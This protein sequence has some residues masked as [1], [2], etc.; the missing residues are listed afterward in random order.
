M[1]SAPNTPDRDSSPARSLRSRMGSLMRRNTSFGLPRPSTPR[2]STSKGSLKVE[3]PPPE[4]APAAG[5]AVPS[6]VQESPS[7][8]AAAS[9]A[10][11]APAAPAPAGVQ[12]P[13]PLVNE[14]TVTKEPVP[15]PSESAPQAAPSTPEPQPAPPSEPVPVPAPAPA[16]ESAPAQP[17]QPAE[18]PK[19]EEAHVTTEEPVFHASP[20]PLHGELH[21]ASES[22]PDLPAEAYAWGDDIPSRKPTASTEAPTAESSVPHEEASKHAPAPPPAAETSHGFPWKDESQFQMLTPKHSSSSLGASP[23]QGSV[24]ASPRVQPQQ[25][26]TKGSKSSL[27]SSVGQVVVSAAG[28]RVSVSVDESSSGEQKRG[29]SRAGSIRVSFDDPFA[30]PFADPPNAMP[31]A[32]PHM[33]TPIASAVEPQAETEESFP[34]PEQVQ[35]NP[36]SEHYHPQIPEPMVLPLPSLSSVTHK[37]SGYSLGERTNGHS[38]PAHHETDERLPLLPRGIDNNAASSSKAAGNAIA[39]PSAQVAVWPTAGHSLRSLGW[40]EYVLPD[41][42]FY[43]VNKSTRVVTDID[44]RNAKKLEA[45]T[46]YLDRKL[47]EEVGLAPEGWELWLREA[48]ATK[49]GFSPLRNWVNHK[50]KL[51]S[52]DPPPATEGEASTLPD[53]LTDDDR[54]D[55]EYRYWA[56]MEGHP[57]H[58]PLPEKAHFDALDALT[59]SYT[60]ALLPS[61]QPAPPPFAPQECQE[62]MGLLKSFDTHPNVI[63]VVHTRMVARILLRVAQWRQQYFRPNKPLPHDVSKGPLRPERRM[64][65]RR[66]FLDVFMT[67]ACLGIPYIF[68]GRSQPSRI[69]EESGLRGP[70]PMLMIGACACLISAVILSASVTFMTL[71]GLDDI[72]RVAGLIAILFSASSMVSA[73]VALF[74]YKSEFERTVVYVG[75]EGLVFLQRRSIIMSLPLVFLAWAIAAFVTAITF[76]SFRGASLTSRVIVKGPFPDY[77]HWVT[78]GTLGGLAGILIMTALLARR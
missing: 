10:E 38:D 22:K 65:I 39:F 44:L 13:S 70:G 37:T 71:P 23:P 57:A 16:P 74:R 43:Y 61:H 29:R 11:Q 45:V 73:V 76:Y 7:R 26:N 63:S 78:V 54:L 28:R 6:P 60:D 46:E 53:H 36:E 69:D 47:P 77:T 19:A 17:E 75:G 55:M 12:S 24:T 8:E 62:L 50:A 40:T 48:G 32:R 5:P 15:A 14:V 27:A 33:L 72:A 35:T 64:P 2:R 58:A 1:A 31:L 21:P 9:A 49:H 34:Q 20:E 51:L 52:F 59:W 68:M 42:S 3:T 4:T 67:I 66:V 41:N 30:D 56:F 25:L 18:A